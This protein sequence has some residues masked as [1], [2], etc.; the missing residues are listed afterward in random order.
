MV[1]AVPTRER[2]LV[3]Q[4]GSLNSEGRT[5][6]NPCLEPFQ[7]IKLMPLLIKSG[8]TPFSWVRLYLVD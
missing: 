1:T 8:C 7:M 3:G 5:C 6:Q 2:C 4:Q